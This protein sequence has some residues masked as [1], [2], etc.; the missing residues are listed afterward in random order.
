M[1]SGCTGVLFMKFCLFF[2][3][4]TQEVVFEPPFS[5]LLPYPDHNLILTSTLI[6]L[7]LGFR[8]EKLGT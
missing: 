7:F 8:T 1:L 4:H 2:C 5:L 6:L 3:N